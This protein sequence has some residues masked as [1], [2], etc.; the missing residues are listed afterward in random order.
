VTATA[1]RIPPSPCPWCDYRADAAT[2]IEG[3]GTPGPG[4]FALCLKCG[5]VNQYDP[6]MELQK[7]SDPEVR[8]QLSAEQYTQLHKARRVLLQMDRTGMGKGQ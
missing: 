6:S 8:K 4:D 7:V 3:E 2:P 1:T 5:S